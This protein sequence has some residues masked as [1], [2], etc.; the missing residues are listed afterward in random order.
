[1]G[2]LIALGAFVAAIV[3]GIVL[4]ATGHEFLGIMCLLASLPFA[5]GSWM[6]WSDRQI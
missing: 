4:F 3:A 6:K 2:L 1:M 5:L